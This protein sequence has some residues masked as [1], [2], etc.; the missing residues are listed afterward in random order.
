VLALALT[1]AFGQRC[2]RVRAPSETTRVGAERREAVGPGGRL[3]RRLPVLARTNDGT[4]VFLVDPRRRR[5]TRP[6]MA[7]TGEP[8]FRDSGASASMP[9]S[10]RV[11]PRRRPRPAHE[12]TLVAHAAMQLGVSER[13]LDLTAL[14]PRARAIRRADR[15]LPG[16]AASSRRPLHRPRV[17]ALTT[18]RAVERVAEGHPPPASARS[19][20]WAPTAAPASR[21]PASISTA[22]SGSTRLPHSPPFIQTH[23]LAL[24]G[25]TPYPRPPRRDLA[26]TG[27]AELYESIHASDL[28]PRRRRRRHHAPELPIPITTTLI[29]AGVL[30]LRDSPR[31]TTTRA[32][33]RRAACRTSS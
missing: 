17:D 25:A 32:R 7:S 9:T 26:V 22:V 27:P 31:C 20:F 28:G 4:R 12:S 24:G 23:E 6:A 30:A 1:D 19:Q 16:G 13:A 10:W 33:R 14:R 2:D 15:I 18:W 29:V 8:V 5:H 21:P 3:A 11:R